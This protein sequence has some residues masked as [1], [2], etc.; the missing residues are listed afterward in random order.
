MTFIPIPVTRAQ[1][2][3]HGVTAAP[4]KRGDAVF[5]FSPAFFDEQTALTPGSKVLLGYDA[6]LAQLCLSPAKAGQGG[7]RT[8]RPRPSLPGGATLILAAAALPE[9]LC[10]SSRRAPLAWRETPDGSAILN[11]ED[12][13]SPEGGRDVLHR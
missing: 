9:G 5:I 4:N 13:S 6:E 12:C 11:L 1:R 8:L 2:T 3:T 7:T 10:V